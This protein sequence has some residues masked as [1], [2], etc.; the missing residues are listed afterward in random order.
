M[1]GIVF[2]K[3]NSMTKAVNVSSTTNMVCHRETGSSAPTMLLMK[4]NFSHL[5]PNF[6]VVSTN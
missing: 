4:I 5:R 6:F 2:W 1:Q 3:V